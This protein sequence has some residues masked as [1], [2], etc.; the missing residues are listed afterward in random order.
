MTTS[1]DGKPQKTS[2]S[3]T[4]AFSPEFEAM[5]TA[6]VIDSVERA[7]GSALEERRSVFVAEMARRIVKYFGTPTGSPEAQHKRNDDWQP[8]RSLSAIRSTAGGRFSNLKDMWTGAGF[9]LREH[10][11]D[12]SML[13]K[14]D[15]NNWLKFSSWLVDRGFE[16]RLAEPEDDCFFMV[17]ALPGGK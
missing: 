17:R 12:D 13:A 15:K 6:E 2:E 3:Q 5:L 10:R 16:V 8:I 1:E 4:P 14:V 9:P 7:L 11:G